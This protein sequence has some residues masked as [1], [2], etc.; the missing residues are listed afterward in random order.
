VEDQDLAGEALIDQDPVRKGQDLV[1]KE[2]D[3]MEDQSLVKELLKDL[4]LV[5]EDQDQVEGVFKDLHL[6]E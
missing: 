4:D 5:G 2:L 6:V 3:P 1:G